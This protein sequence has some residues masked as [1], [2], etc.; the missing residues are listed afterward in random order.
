MLPDID[1]YRHHLDDFALSE[2]QKAELV[3]TV[4]SIMESFVDRAF[5]DH[6]AQLVIPPRQE[7]P[8]RPEKAVQSIRLSD[9]FTAQADHPHEPKEPSSKG[10]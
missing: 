6:P 4:W 8:I 7:F 5:C 3:R 2:S 9:R 10:D 1:R